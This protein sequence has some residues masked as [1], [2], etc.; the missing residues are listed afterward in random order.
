MIKFFKI[1]LR[2]LTF[3]L[4][5]KIEEEI[6]LYY[7]ESENYFQMVNKTDIE[8][9]LKNPYHWDYS[10]TDC[11]ASQLRMECGKTFEESKWSRHNS[12][13]SV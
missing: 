1:L 10:L 8:Q 3:F 4:S 11:F 9:I 12:S 6:T 5:D 7:T 13:L 2:T